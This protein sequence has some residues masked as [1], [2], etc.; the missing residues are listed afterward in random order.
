MI[1]VPFRNGPLARML[2]VSNAA[3]SD[4]ERSR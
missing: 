3:S 1:S 4:S 2:V